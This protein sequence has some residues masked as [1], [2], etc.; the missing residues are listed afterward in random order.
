MSKDAMK[1]LLII[2]FG[3]LLYA[4]AY[5]WVSDMDPLPHC[6]VYHETFGTCT[7]WEKGRSLDKEPGESVIR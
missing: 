2:G 7:E 1:D 4:L 6:R 3:L 5:T